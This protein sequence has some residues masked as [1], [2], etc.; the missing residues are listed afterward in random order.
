MRRALFAFG[1]LAGCGS[2]S[3]PLMP[4]LAELA[5]PADAAP[6]PEPK[7]KRTL[8]TVGLFGDLPIHNLLIDHTFDTGSPGIGRWYSNLGTGLTGNG[9][10]PQAVVT[11]SAPRCWC[12]T[13]RTAP[14]RPPLPWRASRSSPCR[15]T[16]EATPTCRRCA[17]WLARRRPP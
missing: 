4:A 14:T 1:L 15:P 6:S 9:P 17:S 2:S 7:P 5:P 11:S 12:Q 13:R 3:E 16:P 8:K 10:D